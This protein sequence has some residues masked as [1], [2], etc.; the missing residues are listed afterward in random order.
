MENKKRFYS[1]LSMGILI[2]V[3]IVT[4]LIVP[5]A[6]VVT[7]AL[8]TKELVPEATGTYNL[9][10]F[11]KN[12]FLLFDFCYD[13]SGPVWISILGVCLNWITLF[14]LV[15]LLGFVIFELCTIK[16]ENWILKQNITAKKL[17]LIA[18]YFS[19]IVF[20]L[21][22]VSFILTTAL[23]NG[24]FIYNTYVQMY[25]SAALSVGI[26][27]CAYLSSKR[28]FD[29][30]P[31]KAREAVGYALSFLSV[32]MFELLIFLP[33]TI[34]GRSLF[35]LSMLANDFGSRPVAAFD[36]VGLSQWATFILAVPTIFLFV[37]CLIGFI[38]TLKGKQCPKISH[39]IKRW[40][41]A[42]VVMAFVYLVLE[43]A[44]VIAVFGCFAYEGQLLIS[45]LHLF[46]PVLTV[47]PY[48][49]A[50]TIS[51]SKKNIK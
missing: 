18:G 3:L 8:G 36:I 41:M 27:V 48:I 7:K 31:N 34:D 39:R 15:V 26:L 51:I 17:A 42:F 43:T 25:L 20:V 4:T 13:A 40:T 22:I 32:A 46:M 14:L 50:T 44:A 12:M 6:D 38:K 23:A 45:P 2:L 24:Y 1:F 11:T 29:Q 30:K 33:K 47:A 35:D 37:Y 28:E 10:T 9:I 16:K 49:F 5:I 21:E 19:L